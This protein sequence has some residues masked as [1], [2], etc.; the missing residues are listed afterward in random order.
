MALGGDET[1]RND[2]SRSVLV[3]SSTVVLDGDSR[4]ASGDVVPGGPPFP[5]EHGAFSGG[6][7][8]ADSQQFYSRGM[9]WALNSTRSSSTAHVSGKTSVWLASRWSM[10]TDI[11][12]HWDLPE[13]ITATSGPPTNEKCWRRGCGEC[14][15]AA[16]SQ[17]NR[18]G[19]GRQKV[20]RIWEHATSELPWATRAGVSNSVCKHCG[21]QRVDGRQ[22]RI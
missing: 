21:W 2:G 20:G 12:R 8:I 22:T 15:M 19:T 5:R 3:G 9:S 17:L 16:E 4:R 1:G 18:R 11:Y 14:L 10:G 13:T 7:A 6:V